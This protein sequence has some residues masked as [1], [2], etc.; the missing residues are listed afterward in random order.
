MNNM[1]K[2]GTIDGEGYHSSIYERSDK[3][4]FFVGDFDVDADGGNNPDHDPY[5]QPD[6][7]LHYNGKAIDA[8]TVSGIVVPGWLV[9]AVKGTVLGCKARAT[10]LATMQSYDAV[11]HDTGPRNKDGE[12]T[13]YLAKKIGINS[14]A[15][16]GGEDEPVILYEFWPGIPAVVDGITY[17]LQPTH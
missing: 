5:W 13:P 6:T 14:N 17:T 9:K 11:V 16:R 15:R 8:E 2:L 4:V 10:N 3:S 7:S 1:R 12:G